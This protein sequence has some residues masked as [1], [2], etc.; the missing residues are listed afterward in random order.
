MAKRTYEL[1]R[2]SLRGGIKG[3]SSRPRNMDP[4]FLNLFDQRDTEREKAIAFD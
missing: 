1:N 3:I 4:Y 2:R